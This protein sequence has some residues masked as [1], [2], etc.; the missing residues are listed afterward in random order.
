MANTLVLIQILHQSRRRSNSILVDILTKR[1]RG[2]RNIADKLKMIAAL[3]D[4]IAPPPSSITAI[5]IENVRHEQK[6]YQPSSE[7]MRDSEGVN[8]KQQRI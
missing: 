3:Y 1:S 8:W 2:Y 7:T 4:D 5:S 6:R